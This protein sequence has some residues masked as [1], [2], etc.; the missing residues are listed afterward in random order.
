MQEELGVTGSIGLSHN[1]FLA[2]VASDLEKPRGFS[3]I[4]E[5]ETAD[6]LHDKPVRMIWGVGAA[7]QGALDRAGIRTFTDLL[8]WDRDDLFKRFGQ[9]G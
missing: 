1:K 5:A 4:G 8:R 9:M 7:T 6:F 2:K 3:V